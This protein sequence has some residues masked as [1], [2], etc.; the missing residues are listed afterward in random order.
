MA[1]PM[2]YFPVMFSFELVYTVIAVIFCMAIYFK[3]K[4]S[5]ELTK[6]EGIKYF[7]DAFLFLGL[8][9]LL[10]FLSGL[11]MFSLIAFDYFIPRGRLMVF[12][13]LPLGYL[14]TIAIFYLIFSSLWKKLNMEHFRVFAHVIAASLAVASFLT[15]SHLILLLLQLVLL[16]AAVNLSYAVHRKEKKISRVHGLYLLIFLIWLINLLVIERRLPL[17]IELPFQSISLLAF[18]VIYHKVS[19]WVK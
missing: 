4:E 12:F 16:T 14:S 8:S 3:T 9:Y 17:E 7:R 5:Y 11:V 2:S 10:R 15:R 6:Y 13:I 18:Y 19:K 1:V